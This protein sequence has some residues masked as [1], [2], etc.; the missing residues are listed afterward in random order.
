MITPL[1]SCLAFIPFYLL[2]A[3]PTGTLVA[4]KHGID[5]AKH[6]SGN[7]GAT[8]I[9]RTLGKNAGILTLFIDCLKG[10]LAVFLAKIFFGDPTLE[11]LAGAAAVFGHCY[12]IPGKL[13]GGKGVAT[14]FGVL[15]ALSPTLALAT[16]CIFGGLFAATRI[17]S[18]SS[19][20]AALFAPLFA[21]LAYPEYGWIYSVAVIGL[22]V[23]YKHKENLQRI[24]EGREPK[25][26]LNGSAS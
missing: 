19:V 8:N 4:K 22:L 25:F 9:A 21:F 3:F 7:V 26:T 5:I 23:V 20:T 1:F 16:A 10:F 2:G 24:I 14:S 13:R 17:V 15:I 6:G 11:G 18:V 12:S